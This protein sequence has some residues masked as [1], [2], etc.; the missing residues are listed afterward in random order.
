MANVSSKYGY[1]P[2]DKSTVVWYSIMIYYTPEVQANVANLDGFFDQVIAET[3]QGKAQCAKY[4]SIILYQ[5][6]G[7]YN[8]EIPVRA[9]KF[10]TELA[11]INDMPDDETGEDI[12]DAFAVMKG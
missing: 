11:T 3:N 9:Y 12:L 4:S 10:C 1:D 7:Y 6:L 5:Y 8:S 2:N